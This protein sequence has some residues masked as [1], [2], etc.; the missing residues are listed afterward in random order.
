[1]QV[2]P[3][4]K[5]ANCGLLAKPDTLRGGSRRLSAFGGRNV[6]GVEIE[7]RCA[8]KCRTSKPTSQFGRAPRRLHRAPP[9]VAACGEHPAAERLRGKRHAHPDVPSYAHR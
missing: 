9:P 3:G 4:G 8:G 7:S 5:T 6:W 2:F 1:M